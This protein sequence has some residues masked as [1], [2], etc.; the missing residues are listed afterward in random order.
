MKRNIFSL[1]FLILATICKAQNFKLPAYEKVTL[2][3]GF[4]IYLMEQKEVPT[5]SINCVFDAGAIYDGQKA[6]LA[7]LTSKSLLHGTQ[8]YAKAK[9][10]ED[11]DFVGASLYTNASKEF[12][13][14]SAKFATKDNAKLFDIL[15]QVLQQPIFNA[16]EFEKEK[17]LLIS[18]ITQSKLRPRNVMNSYFEK[19]IFSGSVY[20]NLLQGQKT[21]VSKITVADVRK[22][23]EEKYNPSKAAMAIVGDFN[24]ADMKLT[25]EKLFGT[26]QAKTKA[27]A[28]APLTIKENEAQGNSV[29]LVN[30][31]DANE[32]TFYIGSRGVAFNNEDNIAID[33]I[34]TY[35][36]G[37]FTSLLNDE[38][39]VN[40][41]LTYGAS[42]RFAKYK[43]AGTFLISTYTAKKTT[44]QAIDKALE[45]LNNLHKNGLDDTALASAKNYVKGQFPP[46]FETNQSLAG[47]L[48]QMYWYGLTDDY[49]NQFENK[50]SKLNVAE[51][52]KIV[53]RYFPKTNLQFVIVGKAAEIR[54][55]VEKYG[56]VTQV[57]IKDEIL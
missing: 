21:T 12:S 18:E 26:W 38:L 19:Q 52:N 50:V 31:D 7:Y 28:T 25:V 6:G 10:E 48:T 27:A 2:K 29:L 37:R 24:T 41:G 34:N 40:T 51:A 43:A 57:E 16:A 4:T 55:I 13:S 42:S 23:Y 54:K 32:T 11:V 46:K 53:A 56:K 35:F 17:K 22:F 30:K 45:V 47:L 14:I 1:L 5:I 33:V 8:K 20:G 9:I 39:R 3:N 36:G 49:I 15:Q 44:E